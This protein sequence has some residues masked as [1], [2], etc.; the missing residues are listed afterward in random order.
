[1]TRFAHVI[2]A[3]P[4]F[5]K[6]APLVAA[7][8]R[9]GAHQTVIHTGQHYDANLSDTILRDVGLRAPDVN[10]EVGSGSHAHQTAQVMIGL[11]RLLLD[12]PHD[13]VVVYGD[14]NSTAAAA[15]AAAKIGIPVA[16]VEAGLRS[17][18]RSMPEEINRL[19]TDRL[20][21]WLFT[22]SDDADAN[23]RREGVEPERIHLVGN[24]MIDTLLRLLPQA[25]SDDVP[26]RLGLTTENG[27]RPFVL[28]TLHRPSNVD[29]AATLRALLE[30]L[31]R[32]AVRYPVVFPMHPRTR[33]KL[34]DLGYTPA[35]VTITEPLGY[36]E[37]LALERRAAVVVTDSGGVQ[38]ETT[39]LGIPCLTM[40]TTTERPV[41]ITVGTNQ[42]LGMDVARIEPEVERAIRGEGRRGS[43]PPLWDGRAA[44]RI[45]DILLTTTP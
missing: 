11:E 12:K 31:D 28:A 37:F 45:A 30:A 14:V 3:R 9:R 19:V 8:E 21:S 34:S 27:T 35:H 17:G 43:V 2:A 13:A 10:L 38:E 4:N 7:L 29:D 40:R 20:A 42:L 36:L 32:A 26:R 25:D 6:A 5:M 24:I 16:H 44:E 22:P 15:L 1:V 39:Y 41:T 23:L 33:K 18:D